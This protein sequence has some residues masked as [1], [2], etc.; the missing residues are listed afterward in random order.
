MLDKSNNHG[1]DPTVRG[2]RYYTPPCFCFVLF[3]VMW[4]MLTKR[5]GGSRIDWCQKRNSEA[6]LTPYFFYKNTCAIASRFLGAARRRRRRRKRSSPSIFI[7]VLF[8]IISRK[9]KCERW[10]RER[11]RRCLFFTLEYSPKT[12]PWTWTLWWLSWR[13][14]KR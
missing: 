1:D 11:E 7:Y 4:C 10:L 5:G 8:L 9:V 6:F 14:G 3:S 13:S 2:V 12:P